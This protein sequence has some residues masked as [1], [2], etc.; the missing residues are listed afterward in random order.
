[1]LTLTSGS[2]LNL[3]FLLTVCVKLIPGRAD[4]QDLGQERKREYKEESVTEEWKCARMQKCVSFA[5]CGVMQKPA[6]LGQGKS[7]NLGDVLRK[8][9]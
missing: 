7:G 6:L 4:R 3:K 1:M 8:D 9:S 5:F 2:G